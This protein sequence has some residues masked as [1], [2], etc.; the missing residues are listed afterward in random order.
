MCESASRV[1]G[2][3]HCDQ[4]QAAG[5]VNEVGR[6]CAMSVTVS[7]HIFFN[8]KIFKPNGSE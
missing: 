8:Y 3:T 5:P 4:L 7:Q 2:L 1:V 6:E